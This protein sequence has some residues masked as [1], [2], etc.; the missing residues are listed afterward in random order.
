MTQ[1]AYD[2]RPGPVRQ[3]S[4]QMQ[5]LQQNPVE[6]YKGKSASIASNVRSFKMPSPPAVA[7]ITQVNILQIRIKNTSFNL[8]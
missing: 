2:T 6:T 4:P 7:T 8:P 3:S 1:S 5:Y